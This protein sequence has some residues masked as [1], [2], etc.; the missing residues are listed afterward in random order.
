MTIHTRKIAK[1]LLDIQVAIGDSTHDI[2]LSNPHEAQE[3]AKQLKYG[4]EQIN[5]F[6]KLNNE[7]P[8]ELEDG[9][10]AYKRGLHDGRE[11]AIAEFV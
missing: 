10:E 9:D 4:I 3:F 2:G 7:K 8:V 6:L 1:D 5:Q 11:K